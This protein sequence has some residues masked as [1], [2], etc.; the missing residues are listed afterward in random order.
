MARHLDKLAQPIKEL[1]R[2]RHLPDFIIIGAMKCATSTLHEQLAAQPGFHMSD[3]KE[4]YFFS[5]DPVYAKGMD[6]YGDLFS[7]ASDTD[8]CGES[9]THYT[10]LPTYPNTIARMR[11]H[12]PNAKLIYMMR[13]PIDRLVSQFIHQWTEREITVE[14]DEAIDKHPELIA[15]SRYSY[16]L[17]PFFETYGKEN[18]L[19]IFL[20]RFKAHG[21]LELERVCAYLNYSNQP[22]WRTDSDGQNVSSERM[23]VSPIRDMI[24]NAPFISAVRKNLVPQAVRDQ[25]KSLWRMEKRPDLSAES[26]EKLTAVFDKDLAVLGSWLNNELTCENFQQTTR[27]TTLDWVERP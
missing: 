17:A 23:R 5:D 22:T 19:P 18:V 20:P 13:H 12:V 2:M 8:L 24:V 10:K 7:G 6:W 4:P 11:E 1:E 9:T 21:Q 27:D 16:Q 25:I 3:P 26:R 14:I 15:Y